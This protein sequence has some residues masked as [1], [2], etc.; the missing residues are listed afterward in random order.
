MIKK[1]TN[2]SV[3]V[4]KTCVCSTY[5]TYRLI[6][7]VK[8][9]LDQCQPAIKLN[10]HETLAQQTTGGTSVSVEIALPR[11]EFSAVD[12]GTGVMHR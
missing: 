8:C 3:K 5:M 1:T 12:Q 4:N 6:K 10:F 2:F 7:N 9:H 11:I